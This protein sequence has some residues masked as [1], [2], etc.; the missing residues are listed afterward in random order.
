MRQLPDHLLDAEAQDIL[1]DEDQGGPA[2]MVQACQS[3]TGRTA[4]TLSRVSQEHSKTLERRF[5]LKTPL[6][7]GAIGASTAWLQ[8]AKHLA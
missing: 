4:R 5:R 2:L 6:T 7:N 1:E 8:L 3:G